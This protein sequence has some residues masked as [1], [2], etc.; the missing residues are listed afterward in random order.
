MCISEF[1]VVAKWK[2]MS[3]QKVPT[4]SA[5]EAELTLTAAEMGRK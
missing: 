5:E 3:P 4:G 1:P 2:V